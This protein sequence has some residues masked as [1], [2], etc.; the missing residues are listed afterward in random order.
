MKKTG[1]SPLHGI[2]PASNDRQGRLAELYSLPGLAGKG[3]G[4]E[5]PPLLAAASGAFERPEAPA[6]PS[7]PVSAPLAPYCRQ[8]QRRRE[9]H[10]RKRI[11]G[12]DNPAVPT[13]S[14]IYLDLARVAQVEVSSEDGSHPIEGALLPGPGSGWM[15]A[16]PG[17]Q[18]VRLLFDEPARLHH[19]GLLFREEFH[20]RTQEFVLR[21]SA[22]HGTTWR[23][24]V[25]QQ[26]NFSPPVTTTESEE[27]AVQLQGVTTLELR[28]VPEISGGAARATLA[29]MSLA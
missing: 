14:R 13:A 23:E 17:E 21:W 16:G 9:D 5:L 6:V 12:P 27:Y 1:L 28:I 7:F 29:R 10:M 2:E 11:L 24:I 18:V 4:E 25:R 3:A 26:F 19:L 22:D 20:S 8:R 15:A